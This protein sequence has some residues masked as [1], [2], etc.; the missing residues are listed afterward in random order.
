M[1][2]GTKASLLFP[3]LDQEYVIGRIV[4]GVLQN[5]EEINVPWV[6]GV[7]IHFLKTLFPPSV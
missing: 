3:F 1:F 2:E 4:Y 6:Q 7:I 5:E